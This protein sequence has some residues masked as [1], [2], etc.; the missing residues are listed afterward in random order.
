[1]AGTAV[2]ANG[3]VPAFSAY[4]VQ[5][6]DTI[7]FLSSTF[8]VP[9]K[10]IARESGLANPDQLRV[11]EVLTIP[12]EAGWL[13]RVGSGETLSQIAALYG[14]SVSDLAAANG[15]A[16]SGSTPLVA[17]QVLLVPSSAF[18]VPSSVGK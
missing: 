1:V 9:V 15:L 2:G 8:G 14:V 17:G 18:A 7:R 4:V 10:D 6:G 11:G 16:A 12:R 13:H 5:P 3:A